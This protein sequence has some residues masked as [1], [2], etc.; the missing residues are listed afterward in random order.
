ML[1]SISSQLQDD[2]PLARA[3]LDAL[4]ARSV[5]VLLTLGPGHSSDELGAVPANARVV[6]TVSH[7][8]VLERGQLLVAHAGH[9]SVMKA[10][11]HGRPMVLVPWGR[12]QPGVAARAERLGVAAV[13]PRDRASAEALS[14]AIDRA[15]ADHEMEEAA[16]RHAARLSGTDPVGR[17]ASLLETLL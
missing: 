2:V 8:A 1:V 12:D 17:A 13:V 16:A 15:L 9:G 5:R 7:S 11:W 10:L 3:A 4:S 6:G 14:G